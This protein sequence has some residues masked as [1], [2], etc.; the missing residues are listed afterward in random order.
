MRLADTK[1]EVQRYFIPHLQVIRAES[2]TTK[3][4]VVFN[5]SVEHES[6]ILLN[7]TL[8][9]GLIHQP[10]LFTILVKFRK[11]IVAFSADIQNIYRYIVAVD[12]NQKFQSIL[13]RFNI[14]D[15][16]QI[17]ELITLT[18]STSPAA[19]I[20][21]KCLQKIRNK[22]PETLPEVAEAIKKEF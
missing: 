13:W 5:V 11:Y 8:L 7:K 6:G 14:N 4:R 18:Y 2:S 16:V 19:Y 22:I 15:P 21:T 17:Y 3:F 20:T 10:P 9:N 12:K 1:A